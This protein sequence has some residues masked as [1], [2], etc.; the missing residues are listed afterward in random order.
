MGRVDF[1][2]APDPDILIERGDLERMLTEQDALS[3]LREDASELLSWQDHDADA[4]AQQVLDELDEHL[5]RTQ[6]RLMYPDDEH[7]LGTLVTLSAGAG[8]QEAQ[9]WVVKMLGAYTKWAEAR[10]WETT[11]LSWS[12]GAQASLARN[13]TLRLAG[14]YAYARFRAPAGRPAIPRLS[15]TPHRIHLE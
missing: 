6:H 14:A 2:D 1:W 12:D 7:A 15:P 8:G 11:L 13:V 4:E 10:G 3:R 5:E 9:Y